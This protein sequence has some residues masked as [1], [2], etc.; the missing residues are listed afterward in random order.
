M[1]FTIGI[2]SLVLVLVVWRCFICIMKIIKTALAI[3]F[4]S[5]GFSKFITPSLNWFFFRCIFCTL[6]IITFMRSISFRNI[7]VVWSSYDTLM[8][9]VGSGDDIIF[10]TMSSPSKFIDF[11]V[12]FLTDFF[13]R[14]I[15]YI[16]TFV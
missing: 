11:S 1:I 16:F 9:I 6:Y 14:C 12:E 10:R 13:F 2:S 3:I 8:T 7:M 5:D 15:L 4:G